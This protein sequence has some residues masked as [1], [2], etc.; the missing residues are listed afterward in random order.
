[1]M[2]NKS[3][4]QSKSLFYLHTTC[5]C[6]CYS[7]CC[8][9]A[10]VAA[11]AVLLIPAAVR[12]RVPDGQSIAGSLNLIPV[13]TFPSLKRDVFLMVPLGSAVSHLRPRFAYIHL[14]NYGHARS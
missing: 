5:C 14:G 10:V 9:A 8:Y 4:E 1:M 3:S 2:V 11:A 6:R 12:R 13:F 7:V